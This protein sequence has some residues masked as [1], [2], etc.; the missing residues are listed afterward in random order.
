MLIV[1]DDDTPVVRWVGEESLEAMAQWVHQV[2]LVLGLPGDYPEHVMGNVIGHS[3]WLEDAT[4]TV[5]NGEDLHIH[6]ES[7]EGAVTVVSLCWW[8]E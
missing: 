5:D 7:S 3:A 2:R 4:N 8:S 1:T 6:L